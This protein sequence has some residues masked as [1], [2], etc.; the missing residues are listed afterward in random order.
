[1]AATFDIGIGR[2]L[3]SDKWRERLPHEELLR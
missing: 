3:I 2:S 1:M